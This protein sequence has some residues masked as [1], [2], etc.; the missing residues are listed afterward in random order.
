MWTLYCQ[1]KATNRPPSEILRVRQLEIDLTGMESEWSGWWAGYQF[2]N[3]VTY[4][5]SY[6]ENKLAELN[7]DGKPVHKLE[8][9]L[10]DDEKRRIERGLN[11][12]RSIF[13]KHGK[14]ARKR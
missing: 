7:K 9:F 6:I 4:F 14:A 2:D 12:A 13:G 8:D 11:E 5:G 1:A 10:E 3:A